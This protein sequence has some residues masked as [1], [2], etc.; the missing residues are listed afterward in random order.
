MLYDSEAEREVYVVFID[1]VP[2][3]CSHLF[4]KGFK[5]VFAI[6]RQA[7][8]WVCIDPSRKDCWSYILPAKYEDDVIGNL[9]RMNPGFTI[10]K[11]IVKPNHNLKNRYPRPHLM[12]CVGIVQYLIGVYW[13]WIITPYQLYYKLLKSTT[14]YAQAG[15]YEWTKESAQGC[16]ISS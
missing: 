7:L 8:G 4:K 2:Y 1:D 5:H 11:L 9:A 12:S 13:P 14:T 10:L 3:F 16:T 6:E 15:I